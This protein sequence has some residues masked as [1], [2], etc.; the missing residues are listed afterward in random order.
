MKYTHLR[1]GLRM[2]FSFSALQQAPGFSDR[3]APQIQGAVFRSHSSSDISGPKELKARPRVLGRAAKPPLRHLTCLL[4]TLGRSGPL[5]AGLTAP[6]LPFPEE[7]V[8]EETR[9]AAQISALLSQGPGERLALHILLASSS[10]LHLDSDGLQSP[11]PV[12]SGSVYGSELEGVFLTT[13]SQ[14]RPWQAQEGLS[15]TGDTVLVFPRQL[16]G[17]GCGQFQ[18]LRSL[19]AAV[20]GS[21]SLA[22]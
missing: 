15:Q 2:A 19:R 7:R 9:E 11:L 12:Q 20:T 5:T 1:E 18:L 13:T 6:A 4:K 14:G 22:L 17:L 3:D 21:P 8:D 16:S 10:H